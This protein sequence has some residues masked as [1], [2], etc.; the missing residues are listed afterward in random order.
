MKRYVM[1][2]PYAGATCLLQPDSLTTPIIGIPD[3]HPS[4]GAPCYRF[5]IPDTVPDENGA[6]LWIT[7][8]KSLN[9]VPYALHGLLD[10]ITPGARSGFEADIFRGVKGGGMLPRLVVTGGVLKQD[11]P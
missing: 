8:E 3:T 2:D 7:W 5:D 1:P 11:I 6:W 4:G 9:L 10:T